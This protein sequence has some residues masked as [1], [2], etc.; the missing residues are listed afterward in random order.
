MVLLQ[1][2]QFLDEMQTVAF[3]TTK[4]R[5]EDKTLVAVVILQMLPMV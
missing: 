4:N 2:R 5:H 1:G 3:G